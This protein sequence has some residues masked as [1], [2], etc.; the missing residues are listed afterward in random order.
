MTHFAVTRAGE[1]DG[2]ID[3]L[4]RVLRVRFGAVDDGE[5]FGPYS[6]HRYMKV[7]GLRLGIVLDSPERL[8]LYTTEATHQDALAVFVPTFLEALNSEA[9][10]DPPG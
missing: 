6:I 1:D 10:S 3:E 5:L 7:A 8:D 2:D 4:Q 9:N